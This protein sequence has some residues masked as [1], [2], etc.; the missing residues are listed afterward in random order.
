MT[1]DKL[2]QLYPE[3]VLAS[4]GNKNAA[5]SIYLMFYKKI[6]FIVRSITGSVK[7]ATRLT[8]EI[9]KKMYDSLFRLSDQKAFEPWFFVIAITTAAANCNEEAAAKGDINL[10]AEKTREAAKAGDKKSFSRGI[11]MI[12][13]HIILS[14]PI[15][16][17]VMFFFKYFAL[18]DASQSALFNKIEEQEAQLQYDTLTDYIEKKKEEIKELGVNIAPFVADISASLMNMAEMTFVPTSVHSKVSEYLKINVDPTAAKALAE[19]DKEEEPQPEV[20][21][22]PLKKSIFNKKDLILFLSVMFVAI[23]AFSL[24]SHFK[25]KKDDVVITTAPFSEEVKV[26]P[27]W[28]GAAA[29]KFSSGD[30][31]K[32]NPYII[33][34]GGDLALLANL[35]NDGNTHYANMHYKLDSDIVLNETEGYETWG[36]DAPENRWTPIGTE[37]N[38]FIG[39]FDGNDH[40]ILGL[41]ISSDKD[42]AGLFGVIKNAEIKNLTIKESYIKGKNNVGSVIGKCITEKTAGASIHYLSFEGCVFG[43]DNNVG[44]IVGTIESNFDGAM[45]KLTDCMATGFVHSEKNYAG[46]IVGSISCKIGTVHLKNCRSGADVSTNELYV[47]GIAG[48]ATAANGNVMLEMCVS[49]NIV[50]AK[51]GEIVTAGGILGMA[52]NGEGSTVNVMKCYMLEGIA[53]ILANKKQNDTALVIMDSHILNHDEMIK[54]ESFSDFNFDEEWAISPDAENGYPYPKGIIA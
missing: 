44:G 2:K 10:L 22:I 38:P 39:V 12:L 32:L 35:I 50:T 16:A 40:K 17:R 15:E 34:N 28:N 8:P 6:F 52:E 41:Y 14:L 43:S 20:K 29:T 21:I 31:S 53:E 18:I 13:Q 25:N 46:G 48:Y 45:T 9:F 19:E 11:S 23:I 33:S 54:K 47:G 27:L 26:S 7:T 49:S 36:N 3:V 37:D 24:F 4:H 5:K 42:N 51:A 30:G 1:D